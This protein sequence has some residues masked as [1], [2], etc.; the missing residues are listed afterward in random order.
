MR[1]VLHVTNKQIWVFTGLYFF[2]AR[3][4]HK[5][6]IV[7]L[8]NMILEMSIY[9]TLQEN[10]NVLFLGTVIIYHSYPF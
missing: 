8:F 2:Y 10:R 5:I 9:R 1:R 4:Q 3:K 7:T 6:L